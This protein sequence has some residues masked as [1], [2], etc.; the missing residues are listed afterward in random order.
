MK[1]LLLLLPL[2]LFLGAVLRPAAG[3][4]LLADARRRVE[5]GDLAGAEQAFARL[6]QAGRLEAELLAEAVEVSS[7]LDH[8]D[9]VAQLLSRF[10]ARGA[11]TLEQRVQLYEA[12]LKAGA[13]ESAEAELRSLRQ[14]RPA[15]ER[16]VHLLA[17]LQLSQQ[18]LGEAAATYQAYL[19]QHPEAIESRINRALVLFKLQQGAAALEELAQAFQRDF[20][21]ANRYFYRQLVRNMPTG[22]LAELAEDVKS[23]LGL[24]PDGVRAHLHLAREYDNLKR[25]D[26]AIEHY[27]HYLT[28]RPGEPEVR[29]ALARLYF[30]V[31]DDSACE[32]ALGPLLDQEGTFA[33]QARL[34]AAELAVRSA[35]FERAAQLLSSLPDSYRRQPLYLY[36]SARVALDRGEKDRAEALLREVIRKE[37]DLAEPYFH[38]AQLHLRSGRIEEGRRLMREFQSRQQP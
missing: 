7:R 15:D 34:L 5:S 24:P 16:F 23:E 37:P 4:D 35:R 17:F 31:G 27:R 22:G 9:R 14:D 13:R 6:E 25:Y 12:L 32:A 1:R 11:L 29:L 38:L 21:S 33:E 8:W 19:R 2:V 3:Q 26:P 10:R 30:R 18:R 36:F 20:E 28:R